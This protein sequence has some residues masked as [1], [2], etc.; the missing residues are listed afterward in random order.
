MCYDEITLSA[1]S[2]GELSDR[3]SSEIRSHTE[4]CDKCRSVVD[5][6][7]EVNMLLSTADEEHRREFRESELNSWNH[8]QTR[9]K[10]EKSAA[11][12]PLW[13]R[14]IAV[15]LPLAAGVLFAVGLLIAALILVEGRVL[16]DNGPAVIAQQTGIDEPGAYP[17]EDT[18][19]EELE[20]MVQFFSKQGATIEITIELPSSPQLELIGEPQLIRAADYRKGISQ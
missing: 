12:V 2:D 13:G 10:R 17:G 5:R 16:P 19:L 14:R 3:L 4:R 11:G 20:K 8:L 18:S 7:R 6:H 9:L 1:Y 15:P